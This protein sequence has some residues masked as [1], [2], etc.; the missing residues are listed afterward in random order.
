MES[1]YKPP[2]GLIPNLDIHE[3]TIGDSSLADQEK[4]SCQSQ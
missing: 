1:E 2:C 4:L 3:D